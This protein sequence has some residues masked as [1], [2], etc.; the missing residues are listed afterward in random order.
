MTKTYRVNVFCGSG[1]D[2]SSHHNYST[3][4]QALAKAYSERSPHASVIAWMIDGAR[5]VCLVNYDGIDRVEAAA[6][7]VHAGEAGN[8]QGHLVGASPSLRG[9]RQIAGRARG[10]YGGDGWSLITNEA[11]GERYIDGRTKL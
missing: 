10:E 3:I 7:L 2:G 9:A 8:E 4:E 6:Y 1:S 11:T 5:N